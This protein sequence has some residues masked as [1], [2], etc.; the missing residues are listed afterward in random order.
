MELVVT[1][2]GTYDIVVVG[3]GLAG[4]RAVVTAAQQG[5]RVLLCTK[6][7]LCSGSSFYT[8][9]DTL[10]CQGVLSQEDKAI[11]LEDVENAS[12]GMNDPYMNRYY[13]EHI[14]ER[15]QEFPQMGVEYQ[16]LPEPKLACFANH[17]HAL[18][19]WT[20]WNKIRNNAR[21]ILASYPNVT[22][23]ERTDAACILTRSQAVTGMVLRSRT[24]GSFSMVGC[25]AIILATGGF[26]ALYR[27]NLNSPDVSGDGHALALAAGASLVNLEFNQF[28]PGYLKPVYRIVFREGTLEHCTAMKDHA[29]RDALRERIPDEAARRNLLY[30]RSKHGPFSSRE[31]TADFDVALMEGCTDPKTEGVRIE[32]SPALYDDPRSYIQYYLKWLQDVYHVDLRTADAGIAPFFHAANGGIYVDHQCQTS[33]QGLFACGE[34]AGG[35]H[36][37]D[38]LGGNATG[39]CLVFGH[40][41]ASSAVE[42]AKGHCAD[43]PALADAHRALGEIFRGTGVLSPKEVIE[44]IQDIMWCKANILRREETLKE[45]LEEIQSLKALYDPFPYFDTPEGHLALQASHALTLAPALL[46]AMIE[47]RETRGAHCRQDYPQ[48]DKENLYRLVLTQQQGNLTC[49]R[50]APPPRC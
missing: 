17:P 30:R 32:Y 40:L 45:A 34:A 21:A 39:S 44:K 16:A 41:A 35:I 50:E 42:Y 46:T 48:T 3:A 37:A 47:R 28:I 23:M 25:S 15:I 14:N 18:F 13:V 2:N 27:H 31:G 49:H 24:T 36:G 20:D 43:A 12:Q 26:G 11:F 19:S 10:H 6:T 4:L 8:Q 29:G 5:Q 9:M 38:R 7:T 33:V 1:E 22:V